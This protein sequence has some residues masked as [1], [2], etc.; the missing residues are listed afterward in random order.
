MALRTCLHF[1][2]IS[3]V[4]MSPHQ[5]SVL[6]LDHRLLK[7]CLSVPF[8][9]QLLLFRD[10]SGATHMLAVEEQL[11]RRVGVFVDYTARQALNM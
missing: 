6:T 8:S 10:F 3:L 9:D 5:F 1:S 11:L 7:I 4:Q 2:A